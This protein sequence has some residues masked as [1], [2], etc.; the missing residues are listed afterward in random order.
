M[1]A[2][3]FQDISREIIGDNWQLQAQLAQVADRSKVERIFLEYKTAVKN[4]RGAMRKT[5]IKKARNEA[6]Q[7]ITNAICLQVNMDDINNEGYFSAG[8]LVAL[9]QES[10]DTTTEAGKSEWALLENYTNSNANVEL[11]I[12]KLRAW[13]AKIGVADP[14][15]ANWVEMWKLYAGRK[16]TP[17]APSAIATV[18]DAKRIESRMVTAEDL[19]PE[20]V[21]DFF[22]ALCNGPDAQIQ[23][24]FV[25]TQTDSPAKLLEFTR[26]VI[27]LAQS[28]T[29]APADDDGTEVVPAT[30]TELL[31][32][33][34][35]IIFFRLT[36]PSR[37][38]PV[39][40]APK[41]TEDS[42]LLPQHNDPEEKPVLLVRSAEGDLSIPEEQDNSPSGVMSLG[43]RAQLSARPLE[44]LFDAVDYSVVRERPENLAEVEHSGVIVTGELTRTNETSVTSNSADFADESG[45]ESDA[46]LQAD[47][48]APSD[49]PPEVASVDYPST[50]DT[51]ATIRVQ[52]ST[53]ST[54]PVIKTSQPQLAANSDSSK[55]TPNSARKVVSFGTPL[56]AAAFAYV[57][58]STMANRPAPKDAGKSINSA[59]ISTI[60]GIRP[61]LTTASAA[62]TPKENH[63]VRLNTD[64]CVDRSSSLVV[65]AAPALQSVPVFFSGPVLPQ[66]HNT[67]IMGGAKNILRTQFHIVDE[68]QL[69]ELSAQA[70]T[71]IR[72]TRS[73]GIHTQPGDVVALAQ[74]A[75]SGMWTVRQLRN[76]EIIA[77]ATFIEAN[78]P[79]TDSY[80][81][82]SLL[83]RVGNK[84]KSW[85]K[86]FRGFWA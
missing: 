35:K 63:Q 43:D 66:G 6:F 85:W 86:S 50:S 56:L 67:C 48:S 30:A 74:D 13:L 15:I 10:I 8:M 41:L 17:V 60:L 45:D 47:L 44:G 26:V 33:A 31:R 22:F 5:L 54:E 52:H 24:D 12:T 40:A 23:R 18:L 36:N 71:A 32:G 80:L 20:T 75:T 34:A 49:L 4:A 29:L 81:K 25:T 84:V 1:K 78:S 19:T 62:L 79:L 16:L 72:T 77:H 42:K 38:S 51:S 69:E 21:R 65:A 9:L 64:R 37:L 76:G 3:K 46:G 11:L 39:P 55:R 61:S 82:P 83:S 57:F 28:C 53:I 27:E 2:G 58:A 14:K 59:Q 7:K 68:R 70:E 73:E